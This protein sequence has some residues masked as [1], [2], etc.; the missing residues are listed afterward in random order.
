MPSYDCIK[1]LQSGILNT[2]QARDA[3]FY[4]QV[5]GPLEFQPVNAHTHER[6]FGMINGS[7]FYVPCLVYPQNDEDLSIIFYYF[8]HLNETFIHFSVNDTFKYCLYL[9]TISKY[10]Y[11]SVAAGIKH[12]QSN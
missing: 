7:Y 10:S 3:L 2:L 12:F 1:L 8:L 4:L 6:F 11:F 9:K 5:T